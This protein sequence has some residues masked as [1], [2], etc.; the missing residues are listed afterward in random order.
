M[1]GATGFELEVLNS[2]MFVKQQGKRKL[3]TLEVFKFDHHTMTMSVVVEDLVNST[4]VVYAKG[5]PEKLLKLCL[6]ET[7][8]PNMERQIMQ[9]SLLGNYV[10]ALSTKRFNGTTTGRISRQETEKDLTFSGY[11]S[12]ATK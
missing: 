2:T 4:K 11:F 8:P 1:F 12:S 7:I 9:Y 5:A 6:P 10:L 3:K